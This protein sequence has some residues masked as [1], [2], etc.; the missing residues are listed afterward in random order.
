MVARDRA[1]S[2]A[3]FHVPGQHIHHLTEGQVGIAD[4]GIGIASAYRH[5][6]MAMGRHR[7]PGE[8]AHQGRLAPAWATGDKDHL[9]L[10][11]QRCVEV[12]I[13]PCQL[14]LS[15]D[16]DGLLQGD[17]CRLSGD[18]GRGLGDNGRWGWGS[19][20]LCFHRARPF[21]ADAFVKGRGLPDG[22]RSS[23]FSRIRTHSRYWRRAAAC[24]PA[25]AYSSI[26][27]QWAGV[28]AQ[29]RDMPADRAG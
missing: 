22:G 15:G 16:K 24:W 17:R 3:G 8:L 4:A 7:P 14:A 13:Q 29:S 18:E 10:T 28:L 25:W 5:Q 20:N 12:P 1:R 2:P 21:S 26:R 27:Q 11:G 19:R 9:T 23:S 6:Q